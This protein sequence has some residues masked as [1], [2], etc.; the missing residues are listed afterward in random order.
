VQ[1]RQLVGLTTAW[2]G[3]RNVIARASHWLR[4]SS[5][6]G[7]LAMWYHCQRNFH[8]SVLLSYSEM[9]TIR[10]RHLFFRGF[11]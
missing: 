10:R 8:E 4:R 2:E 3:V 6:E 11:F 9:Q 1:F 7:S 5:P